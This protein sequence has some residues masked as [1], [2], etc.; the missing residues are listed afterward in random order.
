M[1]TLRDDGYLQT[2]CPVVMATVID[3]RVTDAT[4]R[5]R[6]LK[7]VGGKTC[8]AHNGDV[9]AYPI[10]ISARVVA[11]VVDAGP[12][13]SNLVLGA[14]GMYEHPTYTLYDWLR[15]HTGESDV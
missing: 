2:D 14:I 6:K 9:L 7:R 12:S 15:E 10:L 5:E 1:T 8:V 3:K 11:E 4:G 13:M